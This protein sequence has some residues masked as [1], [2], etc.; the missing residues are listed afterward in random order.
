MGRGMM[1]KKVMLLVSV[2]F[3]KGDYLLIA[4]YWPRSVG[5]I[6]QSGTSEGTLKWHK[7]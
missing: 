5:V 3:T 4:F 1:E 7:A 2:L 6:S